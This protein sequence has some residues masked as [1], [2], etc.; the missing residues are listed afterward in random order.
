MPNKTNAQYLEW[1][2]LFEKIFDLL[3]ENPILI[4]HSLGAIFIVKYLSENEV[5]KKIKKVCLLGAPFDD[6]DMEEE[7]LLSFLRG[8]DLENLEKQVDKLFFYHS[9]DDF[10]VPFIHF[11]RYQDQCTLAQFREYENMNHFLVEEIPD[12]VSDIK[13]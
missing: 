12:L 5:S 13:K 4:G 3:D 11:K 9:T 7:P 10:A 1:K 2:I 6:R 8:G